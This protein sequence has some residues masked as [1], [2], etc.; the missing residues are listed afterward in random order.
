MSENNRNRSPE[1]QAAQSIYGAAKDIKQGVDAAKKSAEA[2]KKAKEAAEA[3][4]TAKDIAKAAEGAGRA[5]AGDVVGG[6]VDILSSIGTILK[7][8][9][10]I[11]AV[12]VIPAICIFSSLSNIL[13]EKIDGKDVREPIEVYNECVEYLDDAFVIALKEKVKEVKAVVKADE[14]NYREGENG[15]IEVNNADYDYV[16]YEIFINGKSIDTFESNLRSEIKT[17]NIYYPI[18]VTGFTTRLGDD[19]PSALTTFLNRAKEIIVGFFRFLFSWKPDVN[20]TADVDVGADFNLFDLSSKELGKT[21]GNP[22]YTKD[23]TFYFK[24]LA[25]YVKTERFETITVDDEENPTRI[26]RIVRYDFVIEFNEISNIMTRFI[27]NNAET[28]E[29]EK[30]QALQL[31]SDITYVLVNALGL[32]EAEY[33]TSIDDFGMIDSGEYSSSF[34]VN[35]SDFEKAPAFSGYR[36]PLTKPWGWV[37]QPFVISSGFGR[38]IDPF[39]MS[40][41]FHNGVDITGTS[42]NPIN[43]TPVKA[44]GNGY[45][46]VVTRNSIYGN[47]IY[48]AHK[49]NTYTMYAHL[50]SVNVRAGQTVNAGDV[51]GAVGTTGRSTG[52]HLHLTVIKCTI[53]GKDA[54]ST[55]VNPIGTIP[56]N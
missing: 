45:V 11:I 33:S 27:I 34:K 24:P 49:N 6:T 40:S 31:A 1:E 7:V 19:Q 55:Y 51:I 13:V 21:Y 4:K 8:C 10:I 56:S 9:G 25:P 39:N 14:P 38:R 42:A 18:F 37:G 3:A 52:P 46:A 30:M 36:N 26:L 29:E 47:Q 2:A 28:S 12:F 5:A 32:D 22:K 35:V 44:A 43:G 48:I 54:T 20:N 17:F 16:K 23:T 41:S 50:S 15:I 53:S